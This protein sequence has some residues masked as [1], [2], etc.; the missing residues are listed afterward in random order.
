[1]KIAVFGGTGFIGRA[2]TAYWLER[3]HQV[4]I[5]SRE[6]GGGNPMQS[7]PDDQA[8]LHPSLPSYVTWSGSK[9]TSLRSKERT[10]SSIWRGQ[11]S[12]RAGP[13]AING[14]FWSPD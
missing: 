12:T 2:L 8:A 6:K 13:S 4:L 3:G 5:V 1:M 9:R 11:R 14:G 7:K 10:P